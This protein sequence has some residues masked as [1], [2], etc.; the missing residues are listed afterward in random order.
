MGNVING[1]KNGGHTETKDNGKGN[2]GKI[3]QRESK[4]SKETFGYKFRL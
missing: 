4:L 1:N 3:H 2:K